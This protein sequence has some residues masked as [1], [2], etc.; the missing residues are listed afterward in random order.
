MDR[1]RRRGWK[2]RSGRVGEGR[3][4]AGLMEGGKVKRWWWDV[5]GVADAK[6][7]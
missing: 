7:Y 5:K 3:V 2:K 4:Q 6:E 1:G